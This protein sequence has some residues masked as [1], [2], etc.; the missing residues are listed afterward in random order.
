[1]EECRRRNCVQKGSEDEDVYDR[2]MWNHFSVLPAA[3]IKWLHMKSCQ[4]IWAMSQFIPLIYNL[5]T[6]KV[7]HEPGDSFY[8]HPCFRFN[9]F[10]LKMPLNNSDFWLPTFYIQINQDHLKAVILILYVR[11]NSKVP[12]CIFFPPFQLGLSVSIDNQM[13]PIVRRNILQ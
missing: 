12:I 13:S 4:M 11:I 7:I 3:T 5:K 10:F 1:M 2:K 6:M 9:F 8:F